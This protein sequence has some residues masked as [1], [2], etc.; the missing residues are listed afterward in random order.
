MSM[1]SSRL[2]H[3]K[4]NHNGVSHTLIYLWLLTTNKS[5][6]VT[7]SFF[8][9]WC[10][11]FSLTCAWHFPHPAPRIFYTAQLIPNIFRAVFQCTHKQAAA[12]TGV[13][14]LRA[15]PLLPSYKTTLTPSY[16]SRLSPWCRV[17]RAASVFNSW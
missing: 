15:L 14:D 5:S 8:D 7:I 11:L 12:H 6:P 17:L 13:I 16:H 4:L 3:F 10:C 9:F 1:I 2:L